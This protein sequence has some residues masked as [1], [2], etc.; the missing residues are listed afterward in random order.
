MD[1][2]PLTD[3][4]TDAS[5]A[6]D[7]AD[8]RRHVHARYAAVRAAVEPV[9]AHALWAAGHAGLLADHP[10]SAV[11]PEH[12]GTRVQ[13]AAY[14]PAWRFEVP[15]S[16]AEHHRIQVRTGTD[17]VVTYERVGR[18]E[19][20]GAGSLDIWWHAGYGGGI[21]VPFRDVGS[22]TGGYGGGRYLLDTTKGADLG[23][24]PGG[25]LIVDLNFAYHPSCAY[26]PAWAC[27]LAPP[28]NVLE[29]DVPVGEVY[30]GPWT[31]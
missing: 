14:D 30:A 10:A 27:P 11:L 23:T 16:E 5:T 21:F 31:H 28:G 2:L 18:V 9:A 4:P 7:V 25:E 17:G 8:L 26:D 12:R 1:D 24:G 3:H 13:V 15:V 29:V 20:P 19:L 22:R 6:L